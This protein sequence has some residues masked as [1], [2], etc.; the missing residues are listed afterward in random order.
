M[1]SKLKGVILAMYI[2]WLPSAACQLNCRFC[3]QEKYK[4]ECRDHTRHVG[5]EILD[6]KGTGRCADPCSYVGTNKGLKN[7]SLFAYYCHD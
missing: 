6:S 3:P 1:K 5:L 2:V 4:K 7:T